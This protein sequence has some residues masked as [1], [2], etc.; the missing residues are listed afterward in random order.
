VSNLEEIQALVRQSNQVHVCGSR[1]KSGFHRVDNPQ[2]DKSRVD[3]EVTHISTESLQGIVSYDPQEFVVTMLAGTKVAEVVEALANQNQ[4]L[5]FDPLLADSQ[6][7]MGGTVASNAAGPGRFRFGG[8]RD[9]LLGVRFIDGRGNCIRGGGQVVKNAAGF[10][11]PKLM[12]G[13][14]GKLGLLYEL[15]FKVFPRP[16]AFATLIRKFDRLEGALDCMN[17]LASSAMDVEALDLIPCAV[18]SVEVELAIRIGGIATAIPNRLSRLQSLVPKANVLR[19]HDDELFW[20][21]ASNF[22]WAGEAPTLLKL[23]ITPNAIPALERHLAMAQT[24]RRYSVGGNVAWIAADWTNEWSS[25]FGEAQTFL[26]RPNPL[27][28]PTTPGPFGRAIKR[29]LDPEMKFI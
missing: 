1:T 16:E 29:A 6:A 18:H 12:V 24:N 15:T 23:P 19:E 5:P 7:T 4:Y 8:I 3:R 20:R 17:Q 27:V 11:Y 21:A 25:Q 22:E 26:G 13:S 2:V 28:Q 9:F 10:D 14:Q